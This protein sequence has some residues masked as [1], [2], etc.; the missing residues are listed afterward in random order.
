MGGES[1][2]SLG[3]EPGVYFIRL[4]TL[5]PKKTNS[6][7]FELSLSKNSNDVDFLSAKHINDDWYYLSYLNSSKNNLKSNYNK[8]DLYW[9]KTLKF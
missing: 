1:S 2:F 4:Y 9:I 8:H 6:N 7:Q 3:S 5:D